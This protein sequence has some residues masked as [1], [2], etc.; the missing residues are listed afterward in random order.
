MDLSLSEEQ[1]HL[2]LVVTSLLEKHATTED[3]RNAEPLGFSPSLWER[4]VEIGLPGIGVTEAAGGSGAGLVEL[5]LIAE[6]CGR[7]VAPVPFVESPVAAR[8]VAAAG[9][10][11]GSVLDGT[12]ATFAP[13]PGHDGHA[14]LVPNAAVAERVVALDGELLVLVEWAPPGVSP[15]NLGCTGLADVPLRIDLGASAVDVLAE[16]EDARQRFGRAVGEWCALSGAALA[17]LAAGALDL[18]VAYV[19][20]R[21]QFGVPI[22]SFQTVAHQLADIATEVDGAVLLWQ[23]ATWALDE[24]DS[25]ADSLARMAHVFSAE[26][27]ERAALQSL[28]FH[29]GYGFML[30]YD[31]QLFARRA[32]AWPMALGSRAH[33]VAGLADALYGA[34]EGS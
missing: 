15:P 19:K 27:A 7:V 30:E 26:V 3:V 33:A 25:S 28:H 6:A 29:G 1:E 10:P 13:R 8:A 17:G 23:E 22:G 34:G 14:R 12:V 11:V 16:G 20:E 4:F 5:G 31:I 2:R 32:K 9:G 21:R 24:G 18:G